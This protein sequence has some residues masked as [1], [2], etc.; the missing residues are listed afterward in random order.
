ML[1]MNGNDT[2]SR[3]DLPKEFLQRTD[4]AMPAGVHGLEVGI[5]CES[6]FHASIEGGWRTLVQ[7]TL[8]HGVVDGLVLVSIELGYKVPEVRVAPDEHAESFSFHQLEQP[9]RTKNVTVL[10]S[11]RDENLFPNLVEVR[12]DAV[13]G[14]YDIHQLLLVIIAHKNAPGLIRRMVERENA[15]H[16]GAGRQDKVVFALAELLD[17]AVLEGWLTLYIR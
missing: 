4:V 6:L 2:F 12:V 8:P 11:L 17:K 15:V 16:V 9:F 7:V 14:G 13:I 1:R 3:L 10:V 5:A